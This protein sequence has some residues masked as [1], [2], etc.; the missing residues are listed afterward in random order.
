MLVISPELIRT[1]ELMSPSIDPSAI[2]E[3]A[4]GEVVCGFAQSEADVLHVRK[5][6]LAAH[7]QMCEPRAS[8]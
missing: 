5:S 2:A 4:A 3:R 8:W 7:K 6:E 1:T